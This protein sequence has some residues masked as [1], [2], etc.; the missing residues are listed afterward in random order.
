VV[1][2]RKTSSLSGGI[3]DF[4]HTREWLQNG[5]CSVAGKEARR[6]RSLAGRSHMV[7]SVHGTLGCHGSFGKKVS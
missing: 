5:H 2:Q 6:E 4:Y 7:E 3:I 1:S